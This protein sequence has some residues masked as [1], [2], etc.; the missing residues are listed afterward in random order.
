MNNQ[1]VRF[2]ETLVL[3]NLLIKS[4]VYRILRII[5]LLSITYYISGDI[6]QSITISF[7]DAIIATMYYYYFDV[8]W[9]KLTELF[10]RMKYM[11]L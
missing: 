7:I 10:I 6:S 2:G 4:I 9:I 3:M 5:I 1:L 8:L 11:K